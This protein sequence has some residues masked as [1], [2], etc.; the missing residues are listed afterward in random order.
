MA[1][2]IQRRRLHFEEALCCGQTAQ[3]PK[4]TCLEGS[5]ESP[6][7]RLAKV[8]FQGLSR[9]SL[10]APTPHPAPPRTQR[11][12]GKVATAAKDS[13]YAFHLRLGTWQDYWLRRYR[14]S[15]LSGSSQNRTSTPAPLGAAIMVYVDDLFVLGDKTTVDSTCEAIQNYSSTLAWQTAPSS[16]KKRTTLRP[17]LQYWTSRFLDQQHRT[18][19][20][21]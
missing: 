16:G 17:P 20:D 14:N 1:G 21:T 4:P 2:T 10:Q 12:F 15:A 5:S 13:H 8:L 3:L 6:L 7:P 19:N 11:G 9:P 18:N